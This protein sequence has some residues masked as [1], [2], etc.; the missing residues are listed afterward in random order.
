MQTFY[1]TFF[2]L[3]V[4]SIYIMWQRC[5]VARLRRVR[6]MQERVTYLLW[7]TACQIH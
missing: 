5:I 3:A 7:M 6:T 2:A 1:T 4:T